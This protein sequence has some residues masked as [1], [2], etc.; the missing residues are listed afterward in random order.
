[1]KR[2]W[3]AGLLLAVIGGGV[4]AAKVDVSD[5]NVDVMRAMDDAI[6][7]LEPSLGANNLDAAGNDIAVLLEAY[8]WTEDYFSAKGGASDAV[9]IA[10]KGKVLVSEAEAAIKRNDLDKGAELA[11]ETTR[12]CKACHDIYKTS[13]TR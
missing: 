11:R 2:K 6:K 13:I 5:I 10:R 12:N 4:V 8:Q 1:M 7:D 3:C 9:E